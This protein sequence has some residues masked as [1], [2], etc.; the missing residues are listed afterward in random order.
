MLEK[1]PNIEV[2]SLEW[3][4]AQFW[5]RNPFQKAAAKH[6]GRL[7]LKHMVQSHQLHADHMDAH[8]CAAIFKYEKKFAVMFRDHVTMVCLDDKHNIKVGNLASQWQ[9]WIGAKRW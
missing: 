9:L 1:H 8:Y 7:E 5:P 3:I 6:T 2:P 4:R